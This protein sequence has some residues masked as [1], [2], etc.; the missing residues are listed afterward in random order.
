MGFLSKILGGAA[1]A[2]IKEIGSIID[3]IHT[4]GEEKADANQKLVEV[5]ARLQTLQAEITK[6]EAQHRTIFVAGWRPG[7]GWICVIGLAMNFI[8]APVV[9][10]IYEIVPPDPDT[11]LSLVLALTGVGSLRTIEKAWGLTR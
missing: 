8:I 11:L 1:T 3:D 6:Q 4:S 9:A 10:P 2:P 7:V 5:G